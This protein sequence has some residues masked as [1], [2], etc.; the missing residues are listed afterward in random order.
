MATVVENLQQVLT[1]DV[2]VPP[3]CAALSL[4]SLLYARST[5]PC[6]RSTEP[7]WLPNKIRNHDDDDDDDADDDNDPGD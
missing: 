3:L 4:L 2:F 5:E 7:G 6:A 1:G